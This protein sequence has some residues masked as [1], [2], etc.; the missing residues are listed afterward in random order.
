MSARSIGV[1][2]ELLL[3]DPVTRRPS[4]VA[5]AVVRHFSGSDYGEPGGTLEAELKQE[6]IEVDTTPCQSLAEL[7]EEIV[8]A[9]KRAITAAGAVGAEVAALAVTPVAADPHTMPKPRYTRMGQYFGLTE[10]EYLTCGCHVHVQVSSPEE[11]IGVLDRIRGW[12]PVLLALSGNSPFLQG[13]DTRYASYRS[14]MALRWPTAGPYE[15]FGSP[16]AYDAAVEALISSGAAMD[17]G[18][19]YFDA[20]RAQNFPTVELRVADVCLDA[21]DTLLIAALAR[22]LVETSAREWAAGDPVPEWRTELLRGANWRAARYGLTDGLL[23]PAT[24]RPESAA[25]VVEA[26]I[27]HIA[28]ALTD[29]GD[30]GTVR[31]LAADVVRRGTGATRQRTVFDRTGQLSEVVADAV[32][33]TAP[34]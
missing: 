9:R 13:E 16:A 22:G 14:Q 18:M 6:Q 30:L 20:R 8:Q 34:R 25:D 32:E 5:A 27:S 26:L 24:R 7:H 23:H 12:L 19:I 10:S 28:E 2:E 17:A 11:A 21:A 3:V 1:E 15:P 31:E 4:A 33:R 29:S